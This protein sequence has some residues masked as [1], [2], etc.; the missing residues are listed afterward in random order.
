MI[1]IPN[2]ASTLSRQGVGKVVLA[3]AAGFGGRVP[4]GSLSQLSE[5]SRG[6]PALPV[7]S[8]GM[9]LTGRYWSVVDNSMAVDNLGV[10]R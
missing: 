9:T 4:G 7:C 6:R 2:A 1:S 5:M 3:P 10:G 8:R